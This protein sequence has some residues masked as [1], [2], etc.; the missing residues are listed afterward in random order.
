MIRISGKAAIRIFGTRILPVLTD[1]RGRLR[2]SSTMTNMRRFKSFTL[3]P[4]RSRVRATNCG[5]P[6]KSSI[7]ADT[8]SPGPN[9]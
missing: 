1:E 8:I 7:S 4:D 5:L 6:F 9:M 3:D 2:F